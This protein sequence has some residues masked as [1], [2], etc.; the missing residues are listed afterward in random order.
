MTNLLEFSSKTLT[1]FANGVQTDVIFTD[2]SKAFDTVNHDLLISKLEGLGF[3]ICAV[4]W[5][6]SYLKSRVQYV[7][8]NG[9]LSSRVIQVSSG[10]PQGSH[11]GPLL[12]NLFINDLPSVILNS[13]IL[14]YADDVKLFIPLSN[15]TSSVLLQ[16]DLNRLNTWCNA[17]RL[18][19]NCS[20]CKVMS[21]TRRNLAPTSYFIGT[22]LLER[23]HLFKDLGILLDSKLR[24]AEHINL[25]VNKAYGVL[26]LIKRW[27]KEFN[28]PYTT[29]LLFTSLVRPILEYGSLLWN[30]SYNIYAN[31][32]ESVQ[33]QFLLFALRRWFSNRDANLPPYD[34]R[35]LLI[36]LPSLRN[37]RTVLG[38]SFVN[39]LINGLVDSVYL[40]HS[41]KFTIPSRVLRNSIP[42]KLEFF[43][44]N[45]LCN[46]P[47]RRM[48]GDFNNYHEFF[49]I[50][51]TSFSV[52][53][54]LL[55]HLKLN[56][57][58]L[59][60]EHNAL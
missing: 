16:D 36:D 53:R 46:E 42:L 21:F 30:P 45:F 55:L 49:S 47:L 17:N 43:R 60:D 4:T 7:K 57:V 50:G 13:E 3:S 23:V 28:D 25:T 2:F 44:S 11:L 39:N 58:L 12:F 38:I 48:C 24:Y 35:L 15:S 34:N 14:M 33:K 26:A 1:G 9:C 56:S 18:F 8:F 22:S 41:L 10:V 59:A 37:R 52:K 32:L 51:D 54:T 6:E 5:I 27:A 19:L 29:K 31:K 20:K 40:L